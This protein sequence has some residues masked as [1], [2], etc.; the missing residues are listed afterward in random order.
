MPSDADRRRAMADLGRQA[1]R[2]VNLILH[3]DLPR[4]DIQIEIENF[5]ERCL[6]RYP[7]G[8]AL[9][10]M[11]YAG[12]FERIWEQWGDERPDARS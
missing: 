9:F 4:V 8:E 11:I 10:D 3:S 5:R 6:A 7:D 12:R 2:I 1:D